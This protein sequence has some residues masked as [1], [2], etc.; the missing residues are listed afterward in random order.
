VE[1]VLNC[2]IVGGDSSVNTSAT[3]QQFRVFSPGTPREIHAP[4]GTTDDTSPSR[5]LMRYIGTWG[6]AYVPSLTMIPKLR[7]DRPGRGGDHESF[8]DQAYPGVRF[9]ETMESPN[10]GTTASHQHSPND[11]PS[12]VTPAYTATVAQVVIA[13]AASL[14]R[15]PGPPQ[16][17]TAT[18]NTSTVKLGWAAPTTGAPVDHFVIAG[19]DVGENFYRTRVVVPGSATSHTV[20]AAGLGLS[21]ST[22]FF[23]SVAAVDGA[24]HESLFAYPEYRC[25]AGSCVVP[26]KALDVTVRN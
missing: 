7:E 1:A 11:L 6:H 8:I 24:G 26:P 19:R 18:G 4:D 12:F 3:L 10:A 9:I 15:A 13:T 2:D 16:S 14:A 25:D 22:A 20:S 21:S 23:V 5:G 17:P